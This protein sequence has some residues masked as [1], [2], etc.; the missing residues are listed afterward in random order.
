[1]TDIPDDLLERMAKAAQEAM[2]LSNLTD[3]AIRV[4]SALRPGDRFVNAKGEACV[5]ARAEPTREMCN[6]GMRR[7]VLRG[8]MADVYKAML[9]AL[10][11][12]EG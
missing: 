11:E 9:A 1:M 6:A 7:S 2:I 5:V 12:E 3:K 10:T 4:V 8:S